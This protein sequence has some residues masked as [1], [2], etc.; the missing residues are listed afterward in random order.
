MVVGAEEDDE[1]EVS[2]SWSG[3]GLGS[4]VLG[5]DGAEEGSVVSK[6]ESGSKGLR[7]GRSIA[8]RWAYTTVDA[9]GDVDGI[10]RARED[11]RYCRQESC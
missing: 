8:F 10:L 9:L 4:W 7:F 6:H 5:G 2:G 3:L 1:E 11:V